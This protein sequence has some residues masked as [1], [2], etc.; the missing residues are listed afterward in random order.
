MQCNRRLLAAGDH[1]VV[2]Q[3]S[4]GAVHLTIGAVTLR[5]HGDAIASLSLTLD[6]ATRALRGE[7]S[8]VHEVML[9]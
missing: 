7:P 8:T 3:C 5:L 2:E 9:S 4:C 6:Q 1:S